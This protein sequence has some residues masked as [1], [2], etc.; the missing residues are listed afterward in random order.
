MIKTD[1]ISNV[2]EANN[3]IIIAADKFNTITV[4]D[5]HIQICQIQIQEIWTI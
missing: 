5:G 4:N 3:T 2:L 1:N